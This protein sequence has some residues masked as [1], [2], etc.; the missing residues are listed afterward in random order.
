MPVALLSDLARMR[1]QTISFF[2]VGFLNKSTQRGKRRSAD[3]AASYKEI[4]PL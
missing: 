3:G 2:L 4:R 1:M